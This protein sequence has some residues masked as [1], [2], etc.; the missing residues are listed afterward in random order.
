MKSQSTIIPIAG[1]KGGVGK[2]LLAANISIALAE[3]GHSTVVV[4]LDFGGSNLYSFL[5]LPNKYKGIGDYLHNKQTKFED[6]LVQTD[7]KQLRYIPGDGQVPFM[8]NLGFAQKLKLLKNIKAIKAEFV[9]LDLGAGATFNTLDFFRVNRKG[10][11]ITSTEKVAQMNMLAFLK[12]LAYRIVDRS[13]PK[14]GQIRNLINEHFHDGM[15][16]EQVTVGSLIEQI[17]CEDKQLANT[18]RNHCAAYSPRLVFN[19]VKHPDKLNNLK[20]ISQVGAHVFSLKIDHFGVVFHDDEVPESIDKGDPLL[21]YR[22]DCPAARCINILAGRIV[23]MWDD[24]F[25]DSERK[26]L[27]NTQRVYS[28]LFPAVNE[29]IMFDKSC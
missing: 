21:K 3:L 10:L 16:E 6:L 25:E 4:D 11:I 22:P 14:K 15:R 18:I 24:G 20:N 9:I 28:Q 12:N 1:G 17:E 23:Q 29:Q 5:G 2:S 27:Y 19:Q 26:L 13:A 7:W 8:A